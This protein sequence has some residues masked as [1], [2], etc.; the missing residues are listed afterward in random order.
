MSHLF[1]KSSY[2]TF[3][4]TLNLLIYCIILPSGFTDLADYLFRDLLLLSFV[5]FADSRFED[6]INGSVVRCPKFGPMVSLEP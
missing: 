4:T 6:G 5:D 1:D 2:S 3:K